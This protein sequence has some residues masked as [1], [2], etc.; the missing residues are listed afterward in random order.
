MPFQKGN[1]YSKG[2]G[3]P[4]GS[5]NPFYAAL[6]DIADKSSKDVLRR[7]IADARNGS[8]KAQELL[9]T[10]LWPQ[11]AGGRPIFMELPPIVTLAD[12]GKALDEITAATVDGRLTAEEGERLT[13]LVETKMKF[14][15]VVDL[16]ARLEAL[17][18][19]AARDAPED[20]R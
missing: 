14:L 20:E 2:K 8:P 13:K 1:T 19:G 11:R 6:D 9:L 7:T 4:K 15:E 18:R 12:V 10:R 3:R 17:E 5:R 16:Q